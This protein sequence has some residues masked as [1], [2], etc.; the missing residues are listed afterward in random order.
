MK[1]CGRATSRGVSRLECAVLDNDPGVSRDDARPKAQGIAML[2]RRKT[3]HWLGGLGFAL[4]PRA[5]W[6]QQSRNVRL[7]VPAAPGGAIDAIGRLYADR[8]KDTL[9][10]TWVVENR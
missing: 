2:T 6:A 1:H 8:L 5:A 9:G 10:Q 4:P 7:I 3:L